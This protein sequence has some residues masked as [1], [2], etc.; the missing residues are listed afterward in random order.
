MGN[1]RVELSILMVLFINKFAG[2]GN[3]G[4]M[5]K[6]TIRKAIEKISLLDMSN[7]D[8]DK[9]RRKVVKKDKV[10]LSNLI[11]GINPSWRGT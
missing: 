10:F 1:D 5:S 9:L 3:G 4:A 6:E 11:E 2:Y 7:D 8:F